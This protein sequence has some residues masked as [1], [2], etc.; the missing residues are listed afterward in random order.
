MNPRILRSYWLLSV[1]L[2]IQIALATQF[3]YLP[4]FGLPSRNAEIFPNIIAEMEQI[5][6]MPR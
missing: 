6:L 1:V 5:D 4:V 3:V 2:T